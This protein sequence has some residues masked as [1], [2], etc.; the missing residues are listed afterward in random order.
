MKARI[1]RLRDE[2][3]NLVSISQRQPFTR[4]LL[5]NK[6]KKNQK[7]GNVTKAT[8]PRE[9]IQMDTVHFGMVFAFTSVDTFAKDVAVKLYPNTHQ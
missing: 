7:R 4:S 3:R 2:N 1:Y 8:K 9:V 6:W 5:R